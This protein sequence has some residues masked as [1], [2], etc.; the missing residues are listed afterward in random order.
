MEKY[1]YKCGNEACGH[2]F[3]AEHPNSCPRCNCDD[4]IIIGE[5]RAIKIRILIGILIVSLIG[6]G[7]YFMSPKDK[8]EC[9]CKHP[10]ENH[11][12]CCDQFTST[13]TESGEYPLQWETQENYIKIKINLLIFDS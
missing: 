2:I 3:V 5:S 9:L 4:F 10:T 1:K 7:W 8:E 13:I 6:I 12:E 11:L